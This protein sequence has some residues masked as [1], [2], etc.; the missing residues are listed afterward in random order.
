MIYPLEARK[1]H[2]AKFFQVIGRTSSLGEAG[3]MAANT[4]SRGPI[5][6]VFKGNASAMSTTTANA[7]KDTG[8]TPELLELADDVSAFRQIIPKAR[9]VSF[10]SRPVIETAGATA[11]FVGENQSIP[12]QALQFTN[13]TQEYSK[14]QIIIVL[15]R[16]FIRLGNGA[17]AE[18]LNSLH[19][20]F[21]LSLGNAFLSTLPS[22]PTQ[23][24]AGIW[25]GLS[26]AQLVSSTGS[27]SSQIAAD[28]FICGPDCHGLDQHERQH[29]VMERAVLGDA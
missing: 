15:S 9:R 19:N 18:I 2:L 23:R 3:M 7:L 6:D 5:V 25:C 13:G 24:P 26:G 10:N 29:G 20:D 17:E 4:W 8:L 28:R 21:S 1:S 14:L 11:T 12:L 27:T 16:E 22:T